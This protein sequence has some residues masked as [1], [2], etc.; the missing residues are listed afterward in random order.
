MSRAQLWKVE[1]RVS[2]HALWQSTI[3][4]ISEGG[5]TGD[6]GE[7]RTLIPMWEHDFERRQKSDA[8]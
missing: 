7:K 6:C 8:P 2:Q 3:L 5:S 4:F 1:T